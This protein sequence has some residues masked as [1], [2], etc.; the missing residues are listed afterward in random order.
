MENEHVERIREVRDRMVANP[1]ELFDPNFGNI[2]VEFAAL[3][4]SATET[5]DKT[6]RRTMWLTW[7]IVVLTAAVVIL[8]FVLA[9]VAPK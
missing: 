3:I 7:A 8:P 5:L 1:N 2:A 6:Q 4:V 9:D